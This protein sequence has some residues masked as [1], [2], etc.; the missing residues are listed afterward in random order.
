MPL[1]PGE[2]RG[3]ANSDGGQFDGGDGGTLEEFLSA[4]YNNVP[5]SEFLASVCDK[6]KIQFIL[7][8]SAFR[9][10]TIDPATAPV[11]I[12][13]QHVRA[14]MLLELVLGECNLSYVVDDGIL[15]VS[16][17]DKINTQLITRVYDCRAILN[18]DPKAEPNDKRDSNGGVIRQ[19]AIEGKH[20]RPTERDRFTNWSKRARQLRHPQ[21]NARN[22]GRKANRSNLYYDCVADMGR[23]RRAGNNLRIQRFARGQ[24]NP[25]SSTASCGLAGA[26]RRQISGDGEEVSEWPVSRGKNSDRHGRAMWL[27]KVPLLASTANAIGGFMIALPTAYCWPPTN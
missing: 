10:A 3:R 9:D 23:R 5:L 2:N 20:R 1:K 15:R 25:R 4:E 19:S 16:T 8:R 13:L 26:N 14:K 22:A 21:S 7:D 6:L 12:K 18:V 27:K 11:E 24:P 17:M